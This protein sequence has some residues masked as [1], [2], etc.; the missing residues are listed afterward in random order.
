MRIEKI[1]IREELYGDHSS[2]ASVPTC[3]VWGCQL[4]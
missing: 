4:F 1:Y 3:S 2:E